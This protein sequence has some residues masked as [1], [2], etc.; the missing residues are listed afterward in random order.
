[1]TPK[2][3][4]GWYLRDGENEERWWDGESWTDAI[5]PLVA[6]SPSTKR[7]GLDAG[8]TFAVVI[9]VLVMLGGL[10]SLI[11]GRV[12]YSDAPDGFTSADGVIVEY[13]PNRGDDH[14]APRV[15]YSVDG[16]TYSI[17]GPPLSRCDRALNAERGVFYD[18]ADPADVVFDYPI[19]TSIARGFFVLGALCLIGSA[20]GAS[21][22]LRRYLNSRKRAPD[23]RRASMTSD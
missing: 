11:V 20:I 14:C 5:K 23:Q 22:I 21:F 1:M 13:I 2:P 3:P 16:V 19:S 9:V 15:E 10:V 7:R 17:T 4:A 18:P 12:L 8:E 6:D